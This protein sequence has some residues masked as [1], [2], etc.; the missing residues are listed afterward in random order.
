MTLNRRKDVILPGKS[1]PA[2][3]CFGSTMETVNNRTISQI[4]SKLTKKTLE[5]RL[6]LLSTLNRIHIF[7]DVLIINFELENGG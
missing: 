4:C 5:R 2:C 1:Q 6:C 7:S 3:N